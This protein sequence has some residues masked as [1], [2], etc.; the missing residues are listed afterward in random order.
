MHRREWIK[1][2][3]SCDKPALPLKRKRR[4]KTAAPG[5]ITGSPLKQLDERL[6]QPDMTYAYSLPLH[7]GGRRRSSRTIQNELMQDMQDIVEMTTHLP[8]KTLQQLV[9]QGTCETTTVSE[10]ENVVHETAQVPEKMLSE[11][12]QLLPNSEL[13]LKI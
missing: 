2:K 9:R 8:L 11:M 12:C 10:P 1:T 4:K 5:F 3:Q 7:M 13:Q 6:I